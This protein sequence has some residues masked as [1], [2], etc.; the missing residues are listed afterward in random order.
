APWEGGGAGDGP[1][2]L[3]ESRSRPWL[4]LEPRHPARHAPQVFGVGRSE[5][6]REPRLLDAHHPDVCAREGREGDQCERPGGGRQRGSRSRSKP[7][8]ARFARISAS[9]T[10]RAS[11]FT[12]WRSTTTSRVSFCFGSGYAPRTTFAMPTAAFSS[13]VW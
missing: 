5:A 7:A 6:R 9:A 4:A 1:P 13:P 11:A 3:P 10:G 12:G 8:S 2:P